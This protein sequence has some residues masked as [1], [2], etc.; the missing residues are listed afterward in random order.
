MDSDRGAAPW[1]DSEQ[2]PVTHKGRIKSPWL[3]LWLWCEGAWQELLYLALPTECVV[4][5]REDHTLCPGCAA[6]LRKQTAAPFRAEHSADALVSVL[7]E[8][9]LGVIAAGE[10]RDALA[11]AILAFKNHGRTELCAPLARAL[12]RGLACVLEQVSGTVEPHTR[13]APGRAGAHGN[14]NPVEPAGEVWLVPIPSTGS[15]WRRRGYDPVAMILRSLVHEGR[16]PSGVVIAPILRIKTT[17]PW[18]RHHQKGLGRAA[19]GNNVRNTMKIKHN[20]DRFFWPTAN[21]NG[22][23]IVLVDDVLTTGSTL[24]EAVKT[25]EKAGLDVRSALVLA[26]ARAPEGSQ[27]SHFKKG[28]AEN[29]FAVKDE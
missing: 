20:K 22:Q 27:E 21:P 8:S 11:A 4:C 2:H 10:Y 12:A 5:C 3:R 23:V 28:L 25:L 13:E 19:R 14:T 29:F 6:V 24:R 16:L 15:G 9:H 17:L 1:V 18:R 26:A 7:G